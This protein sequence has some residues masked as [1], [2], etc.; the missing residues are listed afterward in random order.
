MRKSFQISPTA[1]RSISRL[2]AN[3][4]ARR[5][6]NTSD[7]ALTGNSKNF[8]SLRLPRPLTNQEDDRKL[9][10]CLRSIRRRPGFD[11]NERYSPI[12]RPKPAKKETQK[13][14]KKRTSWPRPPRNHNIH[15][16]SEDENHEFDHDDHCVLCWGNQHR[17]TETRRRALLETVYPNALLR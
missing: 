5:W 14:N 1:K 6:N 13:R 9:S 17:S 8:T 11:T 16:L 12:I 15:R 3:M 4:Q 10:W 2:C 7:M